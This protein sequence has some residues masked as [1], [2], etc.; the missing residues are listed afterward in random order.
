MNSY[1]PT[2]CLRHSVTG[3]IFQVNK[4]FI[5]SMTDDDNE[6]PS[7]EENKYSFLA[8]EEFS[9]DGIDFNDPGALLKRQKAIL[10]AIHKHQNSE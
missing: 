8:D 7:Q 6:D 1:A 4:G 5:M 9:A 2:Y 3:D 10:E